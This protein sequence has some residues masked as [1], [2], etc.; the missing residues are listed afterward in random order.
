MTADHRFDQ[1]NKALVQNPSRR[2]VLRA[3]VA[4]ATGLLLGG[5]TA[6]AAKPKPKAKPKRCA[7]ALCARHF[8]SE[9][10]RRRCEEKCGRC[11]VRAKFCVAGPDLAH[12]DADRHATCCKAGQKCCQA[13]F[14]CC[15]GADQCCPAAHVKAGKAP[16]CA[17]SCCLED[18]S[19]CCPTAHRCCPGLGC[20]AGD[21]CP[22]D[23][24]EDACPE[25][26]PRCNGQC[27][28]RLQSGQPLRCF[29]GT[30]CCPDDYVEPF[31]CPGQ[32]PNSSVVCE[33]DT[34]RVCCDG[35]YYITGTTDPTT[36]VCC[37]RGPTG[38]VGRVNYVC[39]AGLERYPPLATRPY[40]GG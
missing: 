23:V 8:R 19:G 33:P 14:R 24:P 35:H 28:P 29:G 39:P 38:Q 17:G 22:E 4:L 21:T 25:G 30:T 37:G 36:W 20:V 3:A 10:Q 9:T 7:K 31:W 11:R 40:G 32:A 16:C 1:L 12:P 15:H 18:P 5:A 2:G 13:T 27:C 26:R 6:A 34:S